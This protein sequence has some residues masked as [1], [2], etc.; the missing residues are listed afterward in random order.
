VNEKIEDFLLKCPLYKEHKLDLSLLNFVYEIRTLRG[1]LDAFCVKCEKE[2]TFAHKIDHLVA[3]REKTFG[4]EESMNISVP[5][6]NSVLRN[7]SS[8]DNVF[9][10]KYVFGETFCCARGAHIIIIYFM[11]VEGIL[12]KIGQF[13]SIADLESGKIKKYRQVLKGNYYNELSKA[14]GLKAHGIGVGSFVYLRR[15]FEDLLDRAHD[16]CSKDENWNKDKYNRARVVEKIELLRDALPECLVKNKKIY[17]ILSKGLH[18]LT[19]DECLNFFDVVQEGIELILD[20]VLA[21][22][23][24]RKKEKSIEEKIEKISKKLE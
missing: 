15:I 17:G 18:E 16:V 24:R 10:T 3:A 11:A 9:S 13:P 12:V 20:E 23:I 4:C 1:T 5:V 21:E 8:D 19:E 6:K 14:I 7:L 2:S 22:E